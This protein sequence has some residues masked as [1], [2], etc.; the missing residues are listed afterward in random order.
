MRA[1]CRTPTNS[2]RLA[3]LRLHT[4]RAL[5]PRHAPR[6][7]RSRGTSATPNTAPIRNTRTHT[8]HID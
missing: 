4:T 1:A 6:F 3:L 7:C 5:Q 2:T 8:T